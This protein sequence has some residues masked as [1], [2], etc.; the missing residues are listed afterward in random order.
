MTSETALRRTVVVANRA[1]L[2][3]RACVMIAD[4]ARGYDAK[5]T[6]HKEDLQVL[7][8]DVLQLL[9]LV[10]L[11]GTPLELEA[12]GRDAADVLEALERLFA[13]KFG[14]E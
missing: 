4:T 12:V 13:D 8:T 1:G 14:E 11:Q 6:I 5:V 9:S 2:H 7:S 3:A 10:A